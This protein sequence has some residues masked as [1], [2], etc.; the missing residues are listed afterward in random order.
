MADI[1]LNFAWAIG[2]DGEMTVSISPTTAPDLELGSITLSEDLILDDMDDDLREF[3]EG[4]SDSVLIDWELLAGFYSKMS[5][6]ITFR[7]MQ[8]QKERRGSVPVPTLQSFL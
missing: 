8:A 2:G 3:K 5:D 6:E 7:L 1:K 4:A